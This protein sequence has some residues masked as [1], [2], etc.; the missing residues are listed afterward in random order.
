MAEKY[1]SIK[2]NAELASQVSKNIF[3]ITILTNDYLLY[4]QRRAEEQWKG[5]Y[6][7]VKRLLD[8]DSV[9]KLKAFTDIEL[10]NKTLDRSFILFDRMQKVIND[11]EKKSLRDK[12]V[13][14]LSSQLL[15]ASQQMSLIASKL[16]SAIEDVRLSIENQLYTLALMIFIIFISTL[17]LS[18]YIIAV[19]IVIPVKLLKDHLA[20]IGAHNLDYQYQAIRDDEVGELVTTFNNVVKDLH[21]TTVSK[22]KLENEIGERI[23]YEEELKRQKSL[24]QAVLDG[25]SNV[26]V[27]LDTNGCFVKFNHAAEN[28]TGFKGEDLIGEHVWDYVIPPEQHEGV[29]GVFENLKKGNVQIAA[30]YE[31]HWVTKNGEYRLF[32]WHN[33]ILRN[34]SGEVTHIVAIG[35][36]ITEKRIEEEEKQRFQRELNQSRKMESLGKLTGGIAHD[37]N[38]ML[39]IILG[40]TELG[41]STLNDGDSEK[42]EKYLNQID[43]AANRAKSLTEKMLAYSRAE[44]VDAHALQLLPL[45]NENIDLMKSIL[46]S[47]IT[48]EIHEEQGLPDIL[49]DPGHFQQIIM[50]LI[51]NAKDAMDNH[52]TLSIS[53]AMFDSPERECSSCHKMVEG[54]WVDLSI[55]DTGKGMSNEIQSRIFEPFFT[56][57]DVGEGTGMG[58][59]VLHGIVKANHGHIIVDSEPGKGSCFH[60]LFPPASALATFNKK[61]EPVTTEFKGSG[62]RILIIDDQPALADVLSELLASYNYQCVK[63]TDSQEALDLF[64]KDPAVFDAIITDQTMPKLT[65]LDVINTIRAKNINTPVIIV[66]GYSD[67]IKDNKLD[68]ENVVL[69]KKPVKTP[70]LLKNLSD[71]I[72]K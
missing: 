45:L 25:T 15:F 17:F 46:P 20:N 54:D 64:L 63:K 9:E 4:H 40:Y 2:D 48:L 23:R 11:D 62:E 69:M 27:V 58:L 30:N 10:L 70:E 65:G 38:N 12:Q 29:K 59:S 68:I 3:R 32:E 53:L 28:A 16:S 19:R 66:T 39:A 8:A 71:L 35:Y 5:T 51:L 21:E 14:A 7:D 37:F 44:Q 57:K 55:A 43:T 1:S 24:S 60:I 26:I 49:I 33:D 50:N 13:K 34:E 42:F 31:N 67:K 56:T 61:A 47:T 36:D 52:G 72:A 6:A 41:L 22:E 18:W